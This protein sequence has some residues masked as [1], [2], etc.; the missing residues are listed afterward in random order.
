[1]N[2]IILVENKISISDLKEIASKR[3]G[4]MV[5][6][7]VDV[8]KK[9]MAIGGEMHADEEE[10]LLEKG[11]IQD[12]LWGINIYVE[13]DKDSRLEYDSVINIRPRQNNKSRNIEDVNVK[14]KIVDIVNNLI[15]E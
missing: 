12:N 9:I 4:D 6:V 14:S 3:Y 7:V 10:F 5:K 13:L 8:E 11:S 2:E 1:M 15:Y